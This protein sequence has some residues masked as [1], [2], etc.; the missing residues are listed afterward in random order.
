MN[1]TEKLLLN[2]NTLQ[3]NMLADWLKSPLFHMVCLFTISIVVFLQYGIN[4]QPILGDRAYFIYMGQ[5]VYRGNSLYGQTTFGYTPYGPLLS[6][7]T[8]H[9]GKLFNLPSYLAPRYLSIIIIAIN[10]CLLYLIVRNASG[11]TLLG[12]I[13]GLILSGFGLMG[14]F[15]VSNLEPKIMVV[16][17]MLI[18]MLALQ[19]RNWTATG[20][21]CAIASMFWQPAIII[22]MVMIIILIFQG[23]DTFWSRFIRFLLG[24]FLGLLPALLYLTAYHEWNNFILLAVFRKAVDKLPHIASHPF[25]WLVICGK[26]KSEVLIFIFAAVAFCGFIIK[27]IVRKNRDRVNIL[28]DNKNAGLILLTVAWSLFNSME[29][30]GVPDLIPILPLVSYWSALFIHKLIES[31]TLILQTLKPA[32]INLSIIKPTVALTSCILLSGFLFRD[33]FSY[34][35]RYTLA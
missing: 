7:L 32:F 28:I 33:A 34:S 3:I 6:A 24:M 10:S 35:V 19:R 16:F 29:F 23:G 20:C 9:I 1:K 27:Q 5:V 8:M 11:N 18:S 31:L 13:S 2:R 25:R 26:F 21:A 14:E 17:F 15:G 30:D 12:M 4:Q 22:T